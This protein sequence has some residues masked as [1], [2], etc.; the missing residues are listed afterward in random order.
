MRTGTDPNAFCSK[1]CS[2]DAD[3]GKGTACQEAGTGD[4]VIP[5]LEEAKYLTDSD[6]MDVIHNTPLKVIPAFGK[7]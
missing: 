6:R 3:C 7:V 1:V 5:T 4:N 2:S